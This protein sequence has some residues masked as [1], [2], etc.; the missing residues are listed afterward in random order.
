[1]SD[2]TEKRLEALAQQEVSDYESGKFG[3]PTVNTPK[4]KLPVGLSTAL[5]ILRGLPRYA[6]GKGE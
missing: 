3:T 1:M 2:P 4:R 5:D 6:R